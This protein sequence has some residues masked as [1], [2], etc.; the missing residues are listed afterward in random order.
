MVKFNSK[1]LITTDLEI[2]KYIKEKPTS[3]KIINKGT[4]IISYDNLKKIKL[5]Y[6][7]NK[8]AIIINS[9]SSKNLESGEIGHWTLILIEH[10]TACFIDSLNI[11]YNTDLLFQRAIQSFCQKYGLKLYLWNLKTQNNKSNACGFQ[12][13]YFIH[14]FAQKNIMQLHKL[15]NRLKNFSLLEKEKY[16]LKHAYKS[17]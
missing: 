5:T 8:A 16:I 17:C 1:K 9:L 3:Y 10:K 15:R 12:I 11:V 13:L 7:K 4:F 2:E 14:F 6:Y